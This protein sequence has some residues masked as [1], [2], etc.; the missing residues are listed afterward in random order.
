MP[1]TRF[2][3]ITKSEGELS[4]VI[5]ELDQ[6]IWYRDA[7]ERNLQGSWGE[8][9]RVDERHL[10]SAVR[11]HLPYVPG[12]MSPAYLMAVG[13]GLNIC[14]IYLTRVRERDI[15]TGM[16]PSQESFCTELFS[17]S[18]TEQELGRVKYPDDVREKELLIPSR[19]KE[20]F[21]TDIAPFLKGWDYPLECHRVYEISPSCISFDK[22]R[23]T[24]VNREDRTKAKLDINWVPDKREGPEKEIISI[25]DL[26]WCTK[27]F[28]SP[29][30]TNAFTFTDTVNAI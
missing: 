28:E 4:R 25:R 10:L 7:K 22:I 19:F 1:E 29:F 23:I 8:I 5:H 12:Q 26:E 30:K 2:K 17:Y 16:T 24:A 11:F 6:F 18:I 15:L 13:D 27:E 20:I 21:T 3:K 14:S 9:K